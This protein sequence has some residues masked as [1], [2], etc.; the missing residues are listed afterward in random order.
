MRYKDF[1]KHDFRRCLTVLLTIEDLG[2]RA[3]LHY[4]AQAL[5][6]TRAEVS[7]AIALAQQQ[8]QVRFDKTGSVYRIVAWGFLDRGQ[9]R[10]ALVPAQQPAHHERHV[11][12]EPSEWSRESEASLIEWV[13]EAVASRR[14]PASRQEADVYRL[15]AQLLKTRYRSAADF[16][17]SSARQYFAQAAVRPRPFPQVVSDGLVT[18]VPRMRNLLEKRMSGVSSW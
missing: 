9:V 12:M 3:T 4:V 11:Q 1:P 15:S 14:V 10:Q 13:A 6:C 16:L 7:R 18:D 17:D 8:F 2:P 5:E